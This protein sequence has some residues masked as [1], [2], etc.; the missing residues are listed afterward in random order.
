MMYR[1]ALAATSAAASADANPWGK[2][3]AV[4]RLAWAPLAEDLMSMI[5]EVVIVD[6]RMNI[7]MVLSFV[8][9]ECEYSL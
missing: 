7:G 9:G 3:C 8:K 5:G 6:L 2:K 4:L 1:D